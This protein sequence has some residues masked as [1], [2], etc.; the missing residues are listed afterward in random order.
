MAIPKSFGVYGDGGKRDVYCFVKVVVTILLEF[1]YD[2]FCRVCIV[3]GKLIIGFTP[4]PSQ[5]K[6]N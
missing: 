2:Y 1:E 5:S 4:W 6:S 3:V